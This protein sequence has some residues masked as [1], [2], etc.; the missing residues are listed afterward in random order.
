M[1]VSIINDKN[2]IVWERG[3]KKGFACLSYHEDG[4]QQA[5]IRLLSDALKQAKGELA[6]FNDTDGMLDSSTSTA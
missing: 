5:I 3:K 2:Q 4:T 6:C 1:K